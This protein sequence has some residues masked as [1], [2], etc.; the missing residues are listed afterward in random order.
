MPL[1]LHLT[2]VRRGPLFWL[3]LASIL[4]SCVYFLVLCFAWIFLHLRRFENLPDQLACSRPI[5]CIGRGPR[6]PSR[7]NYGKGNRRE[8]IYPLCCDAPANLAQTSNFACAV[9]RNHTP[10]L[11]AKPFPPGFDGNATSEQAGKIPA[12]L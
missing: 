11:K 9:R 4:L 12:L 8:F 1:R 2:I 6:G 7:P 3:G 10:R 5:G